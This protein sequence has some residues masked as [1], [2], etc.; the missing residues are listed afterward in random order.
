MPRNRTTT[1]IAI[2]AVRILAPGAVAISAY[3]SWVSWQLGTVAG[4]DGESLFACSEVLTGKW[5]RWFGLPVSLLGTAVYA[6][7]FAVAWFVP[8]RAG[9]RT[10]RLAW[11]CL[12]PLALLAG[13]AAIWFVVLQALVLGKFC[14]YCCL[15]HACGIAICTLVLV[16]LPRYDRQEQ[17][18]YLGAMLGFQSAAAGSS[19]SEAAA[20]FSARQ[21]SIFFLI[22]VVGLAT[23]VS[24]QLLGKHE[25]FVVETNSPVVEVEPTPSANSPAVEEAK[26]DAPPATPEPETS[27]AAVSEAAREFTLSAEESLQPGP[28]DSGAD[29][30]AFSADLARTSQIRSIRLD[31][32]GLT[33]PIDQLPLLGSPRAEHLLVELLDYT[34]HH[35]RNLSP[36]LEGVLQRYGDQVA[37]VVRPVALSNRCN[38]HVKQTH[39]DHVDACEYAKLS[40]AVWRVKPAVFPE[41]HRWL[42]ESEEIPS[43]QSAKNHAL[44]LAGIEVLT[45]EISSTA[46]RE[47]LDRNNRSQ[48]R[49]KKGLPILLT[50]AGTF[51]GVPENKEALFDIFEQHLGLRPI[52]EASHGAQP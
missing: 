34:C 36:M 6:L 35:C 17:Q 37:I 23:L 25:S 8:G 4:C 40:L 45:R 32:T 49:E 27:T 20:G 31:A 5:A 16:S 47:M 24:G 3:L 28:V 21:W 2:W 19:G 48:Y 14:M 13:G 33:V 10:A 52:A 44:R 38:A 15:V 11:A 26:E 29:A 43:V 22:A 1:R 30:A 51:S 18:A 39:R 12:V 9:S 42:M 50:P 46:V 7:L 41:F